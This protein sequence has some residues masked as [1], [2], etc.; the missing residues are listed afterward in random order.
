VQ[1]AAAAHVVAEMLRHRAAEEPLLS[2]VWLRERHAGLRGAR[3]DTRDTASPHLRSFWRW[4]VGLPHVHWGGRR[5]FGPRGLAPELR[6][7]GP[8]AVPSSWRDRRVA[9]A[10]LLSGHEGRRME[11]RGS[12]PVRSLDGVVGGLSGRTR[13]GSPRAGA[14]RHGM[15]TRGPDADRS[16]RRGGR[17]HQVERPYRLRRASHA[18]AAYRGTG[19]QGVV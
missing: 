8:R 2:G 4:R 16:Y 5:I 11:P 6:G 14:T 19:R 12:S 1:S 15:A 7:S 18:T 3:G 9:L 17:F 13:V 10:I